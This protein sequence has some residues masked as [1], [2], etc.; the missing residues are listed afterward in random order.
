MISKKKFRHFL[1]PPMSFDGRHLS[2]KKIHLHNVRDHKRILRL[3]HKWKNL[4]KILTA[5]RFY[6]RDVEE[7]KIT[8]EQI[9]K[10]RRQK[11]KQKKCHTKFSLYSFQSFLT[12]R[13]YTICLVLLLNSRHFCIFVLA[14]LWHLICWKYTFLVLI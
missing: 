3:I 5:F 8:L 12:L 4:T 10:R 2:M 6:S 11:K 14:P 9:R 7:L 13:K 1:W